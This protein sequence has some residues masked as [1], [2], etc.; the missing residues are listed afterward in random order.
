MRFFLTW[1]AVG[2]VVGGGLATLF[3]PFVLET[4]L[5][6][7]GAK[8]AMCQCTELVKNTASLL[9]RTQVCG[10]GGGAVVVPAIA[11]LA[12]RRFKPASAE[13]AAPATP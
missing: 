11:F 3:A 12:R 4:L 1:L 5:A 2:A 7:T 13:P 8:D 9:I 10:A 6:S